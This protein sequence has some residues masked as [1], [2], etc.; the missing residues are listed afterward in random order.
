MGNRSGLVFNDLHGE[1]GLL[2]AV[3]GQAVKDATGR[4][5]DYRADALRYFRSP[6]YREH[7]EHLGLNRNLLPQNLNGELQWE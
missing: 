2:A 6:V 3:I 5:D 1:R 4:N 7:L